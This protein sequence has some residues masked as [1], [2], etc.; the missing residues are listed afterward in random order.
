MKISFDN[1]LKFETDFDDL[2]ATS[3]RFIISV[4]AFYFLKENTH[5]TWNTTDY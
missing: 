3:L 2:H 4:Y 1:Q 5:V